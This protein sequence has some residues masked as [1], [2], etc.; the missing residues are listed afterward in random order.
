[1]DNPGSSTCYYIEGPEFTT[2]KNM[3]QFFKGNTKKISPF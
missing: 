1:M 3:G 2:Y